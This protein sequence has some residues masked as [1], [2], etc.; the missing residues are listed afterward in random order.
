M[1]LIIFAPALV[2][3]NCYKLYLTS[4]MI[5]P[6]THPKASFLVYLCTSF[7]TCL[8]SI[9]IHTFSIYD[10]LTMAALA[11][12]KSSAYVL[13][14][15]NVVLMPKRFRVSS[16]HLP[17]LFSSLCAKLFFCYL[18]SLLRKEKRGL[19]LCLGFYRARKDWKQ[20]CQTVSDFQCGFR[21]LSRRCSNI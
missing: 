19:C 15:Q 3:K 18:F 8:F 6:C 2:S 12:E 21:Q 16:K 11:I 4:S 9:L 20:G 1:Q 7:S 14:V 10:Y 13:C 5:R 17:L